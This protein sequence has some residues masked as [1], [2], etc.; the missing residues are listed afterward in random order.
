MSEFVMGLL[1]LV[2]AVVLVGGVGTLFWLVRRAVLSLK[3]G[4]Q[5]E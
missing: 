5:D 2:C 3:V 1:V 4:K